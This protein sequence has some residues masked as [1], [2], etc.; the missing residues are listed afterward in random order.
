M[1]RTISLN[2][3]CGTANFLCQER[4]RGDSRALPRGLDVVI[5]GWFG[6]N[7]A[8]VRLIPALLPSIVPLIE[9]CASG[10]SRVRGAG[11][12]PFE[13]LRVLPG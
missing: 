1:E 2:P 6:S 8:A 9:D 5:P 11:G 10:N 4:H 12:S 3:C 7:L 13:E